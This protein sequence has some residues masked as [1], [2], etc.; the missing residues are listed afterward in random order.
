MLTVLG[1]VHFGAK[2]Q[3]TGATNNN[4]TNLS[5][6][7]QGQKIDVIDSRNVPTPNQPATHT[8]MSVTHSNIHSTTAHATAYHKPVHHTTVHHSY[9]ATSTHKS[10][11]HR[12]THTVAMHR[13][14]KHAYSGN[15]MNVYSGSGNNN[16]QTT[17]TTPPVDHA[18]NQNAAE[19][20]K[21]PDL[22][23]PGASNGGWSNGTNGKG[24]TNSQDGTIKTDRRDN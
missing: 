19:N 23:Y 3:G 11:I 6:G 16:A 21:L 12:S 10:A 9:A 1:C 2:A 15:R 8:T 20:K 5:Q 14:V 7:D 13:T 17:V 4:S 24:G 18:K 22:P